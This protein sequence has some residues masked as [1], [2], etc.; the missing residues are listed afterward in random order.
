[1]TYDDAF[2]TVALHIDYHHYVYRI[3]LF[4]EFFHYHLCGVRHLFVVVKENLFAHYFG[5]EKSCRLVGEGIFAEVRRRIGEQ[6]YHALHKVV[7]VEVFLSRGGIHF[8]L[9]QNALPSVDN[10]KEV[11]LTFEQVDFIYHKYHGYLLL[12]HLVEKRLIFGG[13]FYHVGYID[14]DIG[15]DKCLE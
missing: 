8:G 1:M 10:L 3:V 14:E 4:I 15:I 6:F 9:W 12:S 7:H 13:R 2:L 5:H 11:G